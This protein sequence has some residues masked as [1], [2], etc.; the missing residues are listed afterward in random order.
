[1]KKQFLEYHGMQWG[2]RMGLPGKSNMA[3]KFPNETS[4]H[5]W[6][7]HGW[8]PEGRSEC[9]KR[10]QRWKPLSQHPG[11]WC[12]WRRCGF[13]VVVLFPPLVS[14]IISL[15]V[16][17]HGLLEK[18]MEKPMEFPSISF[19]ILPLPILKNRVTKS[20]NYHDFWLSSPVAHEITGWLVWIPFLSW[21][22]P[23][24]S[25]SKICYRKKYHAE[26]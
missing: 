22:N 9:L 17:K 14:F 26:S 5:L 24:F 21:F 3:G 15:E 11:M 18:P 12:R 20:I 16:M 1:M 19:P 6:N 7:C 23:N 2:F 25:W 13:I 4:E 10:D 8:L